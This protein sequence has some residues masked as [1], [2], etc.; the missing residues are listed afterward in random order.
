MERQ[1]AACDLVYIE[2]GYIVSNVYK[3]SQFQEKRDV[4][5]V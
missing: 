5:G 4:L 2:V 3:Y 1:L